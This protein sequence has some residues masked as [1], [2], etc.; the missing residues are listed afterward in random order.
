MIAG[1]F[2]RQHTSATS[3][4]RHPATAHAVP[5]LG[6]CTSAQVALYHY[7]TKSQAEYTAKMARGSA[8]GNQKSVH[9]MHYIDQEANATCADARGYS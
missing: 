2:S 1:A 3:D 8:M 7:A 4:C 5:G 9:F 6:P